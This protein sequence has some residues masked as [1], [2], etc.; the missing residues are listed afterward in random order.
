MNN[1][2]ESGSSGHY[3]H[4]ARELHSKAG[5]FRRLAM[6][7]KDFGNIVRSSNHERKRAEMINDAI[8]NLLKAAGAPEKIDIHGFRLEEAIVVMERCTKQYIEQK[9][10]VM[11]VTFGRGKLSQDSTPFLRDMVQR[12]C[13]GRSLGFH[14]D[15]GNWDTVHIHLA[16][17]DW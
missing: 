17:E 3:L 2:T 9:K 12:F 7:A 4:L 15:K 14:Y 11:P 5:H 1:C 6:E 8:L 10:K 13:V 16:R